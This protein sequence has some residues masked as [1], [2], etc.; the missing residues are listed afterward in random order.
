MALLN[1]DAP[2]RQASVIAITKVSVAV[3]TLA[4]F[5]L[6]CLMYPEFERNIKNIVKER[7]IKNEVKQKNQIII[8]NQNMNQQRLEAV[9]E[10]SSE[11]SSGSSSHCSS[12]DNAPA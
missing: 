9:S 2:L 10:D 4:N 7:Q 3:L 5:K 6:I 12:F 11:S 8:D 1:A